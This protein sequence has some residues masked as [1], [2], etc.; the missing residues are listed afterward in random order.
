M[1]ITIQGCGVTPWI[2]NVS[3]RKWATHD[4]SRQAKDT[5]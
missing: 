1:D 3:T 2:V 4:H 5:N